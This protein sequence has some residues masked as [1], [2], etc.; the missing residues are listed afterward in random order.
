MSF[1]ASFTAKQNESGSVVIT[2]TSDYIVLAKSQFS[3]RQI[4]LYT[5]D[6]LLYKTISFSFSAYP[7]DV[8]S[9]RLNR[10]YCLKVELVLTPLVVNIF[11]L[12]TAYRICNFTYYADFYLMKVAKFAHSSSLFRSDNNFYKVVSDIILYKKG[13]EWAVTAQQQK[14]SQHCIDNIYHIINSPLAV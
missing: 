5:A 8:I 12:T 14:K 4:K 6:G 2:D 10:D 13:A 9:I 7:T 3:N 1:T 11:N